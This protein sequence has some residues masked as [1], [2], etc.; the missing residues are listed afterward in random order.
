M[1]NL[2]ESWIEFLL[3][4]YKRIYIIETQLPTLRRQFRQSR[5]RNVNNICNGVK[6]CF[7]SS[8]A[9]AKHKSVPNAK[10]LSATSK[11][12]KVYDKIVDFTYCLTTEHQ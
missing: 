9:R 1:G 11:Q 12:C 7:C 3:S 4:V 5:L 10:S 8:R 2:N 6:F